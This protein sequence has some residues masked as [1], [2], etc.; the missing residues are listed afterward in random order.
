MGRPEEERKL[1]ITE[2]GKGGPSGLF[3]VLV[4]GS[5][6]EGSETSLLLSLESVDSWDH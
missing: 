6:M 5:L 4:R 3:Q 1:G 2:L